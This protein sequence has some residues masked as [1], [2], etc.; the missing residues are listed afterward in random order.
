MIQDDDNTILERNES[1][2]RANAKFI[3]SLGVSIVAPINTTE[4]PTV[5]TYIKVAKKVARVVNEKDLI[6]G[7]RVAGG[8]EMTVK[9]GRYILRGL[10][11]ETSR[12]DGDYIIQV[13]QVEG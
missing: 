5:R 3:S 9:V 8:T 6:P 2:L 13:T 1:Y 11:I 10:L 12:I 7:Y 4:D